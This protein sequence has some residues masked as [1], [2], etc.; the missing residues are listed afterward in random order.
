MVR[1]L[2]FK[3]MKLSGETEKLRALR[4]L[5]KEPMTTIIYAATRQ[6][7]DTLA[8]SLPGVIGYHA[9]MGDDERTEAQ[10]RFMND[11]HPVLAATNAFGLSGFEM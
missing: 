3:V 8:Q 1:A 4:E 6:A 2:S 10:N 9:G 11:P 7:V 5:L